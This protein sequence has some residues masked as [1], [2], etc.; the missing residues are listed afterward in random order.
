LKIIENGARTISLP[1]DEI[2]GSSIHPNP[3]KIF[4]YSNKNK[5]IHFIPKK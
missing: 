3:N 4:G 5:F 1:P 2:F